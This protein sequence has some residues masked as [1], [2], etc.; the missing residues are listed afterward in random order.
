[1]A[2]PGGAAL[3]VDVVDEGVDEILDDGLGQ[4]LLERRLVETLVKAQ[5][6]F[7]GV[8]RRARLVPLRAGAAFDETGA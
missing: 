5:A 3:E 1:M 6:P 7:R 2:S 4:S 8:R